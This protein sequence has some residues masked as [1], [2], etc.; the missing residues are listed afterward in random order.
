[1]RLTRRAADEGWFSGDDAA[2]A[3]RAA[4]EAVEGAV[5]FARASPYPPP[6]L[7]EELVSA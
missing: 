7:A 2:A 1:V 3:E 5:A 6:A 4:A